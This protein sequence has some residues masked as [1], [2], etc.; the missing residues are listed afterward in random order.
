VKRR[1][2]AGERTGPFLQSDRLG[3][4]VGLALASLLLVTSALELGLRALPPEPDGF[5]QTRAAKRW[6]GM[7]WNPVNSAG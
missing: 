4:K 6:L 3:A 5:G 7:H 2:S 1:N